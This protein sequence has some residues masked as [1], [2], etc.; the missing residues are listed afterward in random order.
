MGQTNFSG[1]INSESGFK[2]NGVESEHRVIASAIVAAGA[3]A[4]DYDGRM[5]I[6]DRAYTVAAVRELHQTAGSD[7]GAV[8][9]MVKKVPSGTAAASGTDVL[10]AGINLK[11]TANTTQSGAIHGTAAN[12]TLAAGDSIALVPTGVLTAVDGVSVTVYLT[13]A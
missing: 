10:S 1:P 13:A 6:A 9:L 2:V 7:A 4:A 3:A 8:T 11:A 12:L 5:F